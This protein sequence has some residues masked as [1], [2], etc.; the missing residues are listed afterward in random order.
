M[1]DGNVTN[2]YLVMNAVTAE[3]GDKQWHF[4]FQF[5]NVEWTNPLWPEK[6]EQGSLFIPEY[7]RHH[8]S[9]CSQAQKDFVVRYFFGPNGRE[10]S[11]ISP[12]GRVKETFVSSWSI[13]EVEVLHEFYRS[14]IDDH[15]AVV[16]TKMAAFR[17]Y[18]P[19]G[20]Q[21]L[22]SFDGGFTGWL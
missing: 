8:P 2:I 3:N 10:N 19:N 5:Y 12:C 9:C 15:S 22:N 7:G 6:R 13:A 1:S 17:Y 4:R 20:Y 14:L 11:S 18:N 16:T 21:P